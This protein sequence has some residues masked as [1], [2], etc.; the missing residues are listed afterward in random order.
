MKPEC[1]KD[2]FNEL[3]T[4]SDTLE[5][6]LSP[7]EPFFQL[8]TFGFAGQI[9]YDIHKDSDMIENFQC[10]STQTN[11]YLLSLLKPSVRAINLASKVCVRVDKRGFLSFQYMIKNENSHNCFVEY[12]CC[13]EENN[14]ENGENVVHVQ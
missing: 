4:S 7:Q 12:Y 3:D 5:I 6:T 13:P 1:L 8:S 11:R 9:S 2:A 10:F 14:D